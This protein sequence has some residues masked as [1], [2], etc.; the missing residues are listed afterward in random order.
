MSSFNGPACPITVEVIRV[1]FARH[2]EAQLFVELPHPRERNQ[3]HSLLIPFGHFQQGFHDDGTDSNATLV[4]MHRHIAHVE[5]G[6]AIELNK[7]K[8]NDAL[9]LLAVGDIGVVLVAP[10]PRLDD[11]G[12][13][14]LRK[15]LGEKGFDVTVIRVIGCLHVNNIVV[16]HGGC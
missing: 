9:A 11:V 13:I 1:I 7:N 10:L 4:R 6:R 16:V 2:V 14:K 3:T 12:A 15:H 8:R 5:I